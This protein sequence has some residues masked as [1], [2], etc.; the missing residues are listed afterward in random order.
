[1]AIVCIES[2][3][4]D[5][6]K[7]IGVKDSKKLNHQERLSIFQKSSKFIKYSSYEIVQPEV[8]DNYVYR[9]ALN[10]L[11]AEV[12]ARLINKCIEVLG[13][14]KF[15]LD[16]P[17]VKTERFEKLIRSLAKW[18]INVKALNKAD[19]KVVVVSLA[20]ILAKIVREREIEKLRRTY[21]D[22]GSGY[23]SDPKTIKF[24]IK[25][26][27]EGRDLPI[28]RKSWKTFKRILEEWKG[29]LV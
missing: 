5:F 23:P 9:N 4:E 12:M 15:I 2:E 1:M 28:I 20:S 10:L 19:E 29:R 16:S 8:I 24:L 27:R 21:G 3:V 7:R 18:D 6:L 22:F 25:Y 13:D 26:I 11:E 17:D 14:A